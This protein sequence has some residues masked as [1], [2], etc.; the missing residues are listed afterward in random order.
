[1]DR[2]EGRLPS[3]GFS[4]VGQLVLRADMAP[5]YEHSGPPLP[6]A[7]YA[8]CQN[9][10]VMYFGQNSVG[11]QPRLRGLASVIRRDA[12]VGTLNA[13]CQ[14]FLSAM[15]HG[16]LAVW[17]KPPER[18]VIHGVECDLLEAEEI[19]LM[20]LLDTPWNDRGKSQRT[21]QI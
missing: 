3:Y 4:P 21:R 16:P 10:L 17:A 19:V 20:R 2:S 12:A 14:I 15:G 7:V 1:M 18:H 11:L 13:K 8:F 5:V 6:S 9:G